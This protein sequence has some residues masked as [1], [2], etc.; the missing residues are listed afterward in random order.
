MRVTRRNVLRGCVVV[1]SLGSV[2]G[3][4]D[5]AAADTLNAYWNLN[6]TSGTAAANNGSFTGVGGTLQGNAAFVSGKFGNA[7]SL[8][9][10]GDYVDVT[11][12]V[13][14]NGGS[15]FTASAWFNVASG[16]TGRRMIFETVGAAIGDG[17]TISTD[18]SDTN[19]YLRYFSLTSTLTLAMG[20]T[21]VQPTAGT[22]YLVTE[23]V[24]AGVEKKAHIYVN[25]V[26][27]SAAD[28]SISGTLCNTQGFHIGTYRNADGRWFKGLID[29]VAVWSNALSA[30][31]VKATYDLG[32]SS[33]YGYDAG[34][35]NQ[36][37]ASYEG[38]HSDVT[39]GN[40]TWKYQGSGLGSTLGLSTDGNNLVLST[41]GAGF[42]VIPEP[43]SF[44]LLVMG[45]F[46]LVAYAWR[47]RK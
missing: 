15:T 18:I 1:M 40:V 10:S 19:G 3:L 29:D 30:G 37:I 24:D 12:R 8:D 36:L 2:L 45:M 14:N 43:S 27:Q 6:E 28:Q 21:T 11:N 20:T 31:E 39:I 44:V 34:K 38:S 32:N 26:L 5:R 16:A 13:I 22:W 35:V 47:K 42:T 17:Y 46:G 41:N 23:V 4:T 33:T 25:G 9:G 7:V